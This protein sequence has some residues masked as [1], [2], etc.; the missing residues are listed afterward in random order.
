MCLPGGL[1]RRSQ[2]GTQ[3][4]EASFEL[5]INF[6]PPSVPPPD[7][8]DPSSHTSHTLDEINCGRD[9]KGLWYAS[10]KEAPNLHPD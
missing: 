7:S 8:A 5:V 9:A 1:Q 6:S 2:T 3:A 10:S 4:P